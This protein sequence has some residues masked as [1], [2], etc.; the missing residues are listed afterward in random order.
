MDAGLANERCIRCEQ[1]TPPLAMQEAQRLLD[2]LDDRWL[3][4][5]DGR[6]LTRARRSVQ[7][8]C[9]LQAG[10]LTEL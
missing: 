3:L 9:D 8:Q 4:A 10:M 5:D 1:G 6:A 2:D 7:W